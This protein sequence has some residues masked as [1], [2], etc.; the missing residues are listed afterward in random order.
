MDELFNQFFIPVA[1]LKAM[2]IRISVLVTEN[3]AAEGSEKKVKKKKK[4]IISGFLSELKFLDVFLLN[5]VL[6]A[7][8]IVKILSRVACL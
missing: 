3:I 7:F 6:S 2:P 8:I 4:I 5:S 1:M